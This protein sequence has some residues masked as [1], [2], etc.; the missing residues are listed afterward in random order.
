MRA[1]ACAR[2]TGSGAA[3]IAQRCSACI[4]V[5]WFTELS[6]S[7]FRGMVWNWGLESPQNP[8]TGMSALR[9]SMRFMGYRFEHDLDC[10]LTFDPLPGR[11]LANDYIKHRREEEAEESYT[12]HPEEHRCAECPAHL[13]TRAA[14][15]QQR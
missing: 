3:P 13:R 2:K 9:C 6:S 14:R 10:G 7:V 12:Q 1:C 4:P 15:Q 5:C 11:Q 8:Q